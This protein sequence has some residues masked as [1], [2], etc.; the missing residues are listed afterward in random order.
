M[1]RADVIRGQKELDERLQSRRRFIKYGAGVILTA[2]TAGS[3]YELLSNIPGSNGKTTSTT[4]SETASTSKQI[5]DPLISSLDMYPKYIDPTD[6]YDIIFTQKSSDPQSLPLSYS[7]LIDG[8]Q[9]TTGDSFKTKLPVGN[10]DVGLQVSNGVK[11]SSA[12]KSFTVE[13]DQLPDPNDPTKPLYPTKRLNIKYKG[14]RYSVGV[15]APYAQT[16]TPEIEEMDEQL[17]TIQKEIGCNAILGD[18]D[19]GYKDNEQRLINFGKLAIEKGFERI[20]IQPEYMDL[21]V[22]QTIENIGK[23]AERVKPL[24]DLSDSVVLV[25]GHE[26]G[27]ETYGIIP[28]ETWSDR[29]RYTT[30]HDNWLGN[31]RATVPSMITKIV[32]LCKQK[33][34]Y[35]ITYSAAIWED[36][37]IPW[38]NPIFESVCTDAYIFDSVGW[39]ADWIKN[40]L[41]SLKRFGKPVNSAE[42][43]CMTF[44]GAGVIS[45]TS[46]LYVEQNPYDEDEQANY[47]RNYCEMLNK[48]DINGSFYT[49]YADNPTFEKGFGLLHNN[50]ISRKKGFYMYKSYARAS[51]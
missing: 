18:A 35:P 34:G 48:A 10:H 38:S 27:L 19:A 49:L 13:P 6:A 28:G 45:G 39:T 7:W 41:S 46:P 31:V 15:W 40:H 30:Q 47:I 32:S 50:N 2:A 9:A 22:N 3:I 8:K 5:Y 33:Y 51:N 23:F 12:Y 26:F 44:T 21:T 16:P 37:L 17:D 24:R 20:Y 11:S 42:W 14:M 4:A 1:D 29:L 36:D 25:V 43:G